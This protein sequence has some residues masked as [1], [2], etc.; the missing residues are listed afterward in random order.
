MNYCRIIL[1]LCLIND[2]LAKLYPRNMSFGCFK[3]SSI[4]KICFGNCIGKESRGTL[5]NK[6]GSSTNLNEIDNTG[7]QAVSSANTNN[8]LSTDR[9]IPQNEKDA[10]NQHNNNEKLSQEN[11]ANDVIVQQPINKIKIVNVTYQKTMYHQNTVNRKRIS[12]AV[13]GHVNS[14]HRNSMDSSSTNQT[15][16][17]TKSKYFPSM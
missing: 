4:F 11:G 15:P 6:V 9:E 12:N 5:S 1:T 14:V 8:D 3:V 13:D 2:R 17:G 7:L 10:S 16:D